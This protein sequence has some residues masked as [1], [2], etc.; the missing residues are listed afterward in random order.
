MSNPMQPVSRIEFK[1]RMLSQLA[2]IAPSEDVEI[3]GLCD[4]SRLAQPGDAYL[5]MPRTS[6]SADGFARTAQKN[7]AAAII[8]I[9]RSLPVSLPQLKLPDMQAVGMVLRKLLGTKT[10]KI[11]CV[12]ITGTDGKTSIAWMLREA[13]ARRMGQVWSTGTLGL[14]RGPDDITDIGN[15]TPS[16]MTN[17]A[18]MQRAKKEKVGALVMEVS[19]HGIDQE[20]IAALPVNTAIWT[21]LGHD[22]LQDHGGFEAYAAI[23]HRYVTDTVKKGGIAVCN[24]DDVDIRRLMLK[25]GTKAS[26][27]AH[28]LY[29]RELDGITID[30]TWEQELPGMV[31]FACR[32][33][34]VRIEDIPAGEFHAENLAAVALTLIERFGVDS[35]ELPDLLDGISAPPGRMQALEIGRWQVFIDYAHTPEALERCL[36]TARPL[37]SGRL[38]VVFGCG[39]NR[40]R[41]KR[42]EMGHVAVTLADAVWIT[43]DN[44]RGERPE[45]IASEI[46]NGMPKPYPA[47]VH[48]ELDRREAIY[49]AVDAMQPGDLLLIAGKGHEAYMEIEGVRLEWSD[50][51]IA[52]EA[53]H[54]K[55]DRRIQL[56]A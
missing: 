23:K 5:C 11:D 13:L 8:T 20:R 48:L 10:Y 19:S 35:D 44:P 47:E 30:L 46:E 39:G 2:D 34:E 56:C 14:V 32:G 38:I 33:K 36:N 24:A 42:P 18:L 28:D 55:E 12:G 49:A 16:L 26:W 52:T 50:F 40:D 21:N 54:L 9:N 29:A 17:H 51:D 25:S 15:T 6:A 7:G 31:R 1:P 4:D 41:E 45:V 43:S 53:L 37:T 3:K 27:Y 22:H